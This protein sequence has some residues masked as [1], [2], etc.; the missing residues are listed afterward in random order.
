MPT[1]EY[2]TPLGTFRTWEE[3]AAA[4]DRAD[5]DPVECIEILRAPLLPCWPYTK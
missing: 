4:C 3:A 2:R 5:L 1:T